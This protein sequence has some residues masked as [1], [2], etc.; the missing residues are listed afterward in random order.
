MIDTLN[1]AHER[2][3][4]WASALG[5]GRP[6]TP[7]PESRLHQDAAAAILKLAEDAGER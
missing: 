5:P 7:R 6:L 3:Q 4:A 2:I 1:G